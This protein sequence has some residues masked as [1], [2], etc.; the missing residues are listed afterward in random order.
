[1]RD[2]SKAAFVKAAAKAAAILKKNPLP[3]EFTQ[4]KKKVNSCLKQEILNSPYNGIFPCFFLGS[5]ATLF[6]SMANALMSLARV[7][8][9]SIT[10][11][12][13]PRSAARYGVANFSAYSASYSAS[14]FAG[15][16]AS[17]ISFLKMI[18]LAPLAPITAIS[19]VGHA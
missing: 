7:Y 10:S 16:A 19:A 1:M 11:S 2:Y 9:G 15:S 13:N 18:S 4:P 12:T 3:K 14:F 8:F 5:F 17:E 6:S